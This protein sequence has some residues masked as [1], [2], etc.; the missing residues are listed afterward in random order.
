MLKPRGQFGQ[1]FG[2]NLGLSF[3]KLK[4]S[5]EVHL[6]TKTVHRFNRFSFM[7]QIYVGTNYLWTLVPHSLA[8]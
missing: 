2:L 3:S 7:L 5:Y 6:V 4:K 1:N 8:Q